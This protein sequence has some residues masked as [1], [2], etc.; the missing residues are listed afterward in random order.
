MFEPVAGVHP[1]YRREDVQSVR[2]NGRLNYIERIV[3]LALFFFE[4]AEEET[5]GHSRLI[6]DQLPAPALNW[7]QVQAQF[8]EAWY[9]REALSLTEAALA[10]HRWTC[11][12]GAAPEDLTGVEAGIRE[13]CLPYERPFQSVDDPQQ[14][15]R[16]SY[17]RLARFYRRML[18]EDLTWHSRVVERF[19]PNAAAPQNQGRPGQHPEHV[20]PCVLMRELAQECFGNHQSVHDVAALL[21]RW[22][23]VIWIDQDHRKLLDHGKDNLKSRMPDNWDNAA[24]CVYARLHEKKILFQP[25]QGYPCTCRSDIIPGAHAE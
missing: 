1:D 19:V 24:G 10:F 4:L 23:V 3:Q 16:R 2:G 14:R 20:V 5:N 17:V 15:L 18:R 7:K 6:R 11:E 13:G 21:R 9:G 25:A 8:R 12:R 22:L